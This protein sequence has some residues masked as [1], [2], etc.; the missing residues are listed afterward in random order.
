MPH[1]PQP[2]PPSV[3]EMF[4]ARGVPVQLPGGQGA[5]WRS[6]DLVLKPLDMS[7]ETLQWQADVLSGIAPN[8]EVRLA[9]PLRAKNGALSVMGWTAWPFLPGRPTGRRWQDVIAAGDT[10]HEALRHL[11]RPAFLDHRTDRWSV[12]DE[13]AWGER[14]SGDLG[15]GRSVARLIEHRRHLDPVDQ[16]IHGDLTGNVLLHPQLPPAVIDLSP[17]WR[18][19]G[20]ASAIVLADALLWHRAGEDLVRV[21][22]DLPDLAQLLVRALTFRL[23]VQPE[24]STDRDA[25]ER[26]VRLA[27][28]LVDSI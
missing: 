16:V 9:P 10:F 17:Y 22:A 20:Y 8:A 3:A 12:A 2:P 6:E 13:I 23:L 14:D 5:A 19:A 1:L 26:A 4:G 21:N 28:R 15:A 25:H 18:P 7:E 24:V 27:C 11:P